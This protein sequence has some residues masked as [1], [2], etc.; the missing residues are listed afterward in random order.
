MNEWAPHSAKQDRAV[1]SD[2]PVVVLGTGVQY[3]KTT[4][5]AIKLRIALHTFTNRSDNFLVIAP[6]YKILQQS[7][8]PAFLKVVDDGIG[9][10]SKSDMVFKTNWGSTIYFRTTENPDAIVGITNVRFIWGDEAGLFTLYAWENIQARAAFKEAQII[11]TTSPYTL[12][13]LYKEIIR[14]CLRGNGPK[15]VEL[16]QAASWENPYMPA[17]VIDRARITMDPRRF[18]AMFGG[19]W[20]RM[21]GLVYDCYDEVENQCQAFSLPAGSR[22]V[23]GIDWGYTEPFVFKIR[24]I[25]PDGAQFGVHEFYKSGLIIDDI[26]DAVMMRVRTHG[27]RLIYAGPDQPGYIEK[28]NRLFAKEGVKC[29]VVPANN[30]VRVGVDAHYELL[31][32]RRLKYF[33]GANPYTLDE[34]DTYHYPNPEDV[35]PDKN[36]KDQK[37]VQQ[38]DHALDADR[39]ISVMTSAMGER[40]APYVPA[41]RKRQLDHHAE[42]ERLK[43]PPKIGGQTETW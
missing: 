42:T 8:L 26:A 4:A 30:D 3:G 37:P 1:L 32:T 39:Y 11:L 33:L 36:V 6:S 34:I 29:A 23:G 21:S 7:T 38:N 2:A 25:T 27:V 19:Q 13:W 28:L 12:N 31:K 20:E 40:V 24:G 43:R 41:E 5:G 17:S 22:F 9:Q 14:P 35:G 16:I 18:N 15:H 10:F